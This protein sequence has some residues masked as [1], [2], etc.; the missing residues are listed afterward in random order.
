[1]PMIHKR[2]PKPEKMT[3][4]DIALA[5]NGCEAGLSGW[6]EVYVHFLMVLLPPALRASGK[7]HSAFISLFH[8][9]EPRR[10]VMK[11]SRHVS[12]GMGFNTP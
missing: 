11:G 2:A 1:M 3:S 6:G 4:A 5:S 10:E 9:S 12:I 8:I 7:N